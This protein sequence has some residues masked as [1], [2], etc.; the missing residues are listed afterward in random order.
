MPS[1]KKSLITLKL[2]IR[3]THVELRYNVMFEWN[4]FL[5]NQIYRFRWFFNRYVSNNLHDWR[6]SL[7]IAQCL[8]FPIFLNITEHPLEAVL[9]L[10][11]SVAFHGKKALQ[12]Q[13]LLTVL[14]IFVVNCCEH[15]RLVRNNVVEKYW[16][17]TGVDAFTNKKC[18]GEICR[19]LSATAS[20][21]MQTENRRA[22][23]SSCLSKLDLILHKDKWS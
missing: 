1:I 10:S 8:K 16:W 7:S 4:Y 6:C 19:H 21:Q 23:S 13:D 17:T 9:L 3:L 5:H 22:E 18:A 20:E 12:S 15:S 14:I 11:Y 2:K